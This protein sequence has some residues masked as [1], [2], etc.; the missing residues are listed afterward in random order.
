MAAISAAYKRLFLRGVKW[1][2]ETGVTTMAAV[3]K[4]LA[5]ASFEATKGGE[6]K[7]LTGASV[8]TVQ[9][10]LPANGAGL[11]P[12]TA[13]ELISEMLDRHDAAVSELGA[14]SHSD[15]AIFAEMMANL[16]RVTRTRP[17]FVN[18]SI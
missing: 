7:I 12:Q 17:T 18:L 11:T 5:Q 10:T 8:G 15:D 3:L 13:A 4:S 9:Y 16:N 1:D 2:A 6:L 14:G